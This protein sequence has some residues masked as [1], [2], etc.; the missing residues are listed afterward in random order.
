MIFLALIVILYLAAWG[1]G[2]KI[3]VNLTPS[4]PRGIYLLMPVKNLSRGS[5]IA[6]CNPNKEAVALYVKRGYLPESHRCSSGAAPII[7][8][9]AAVPGDTVKLDDSGVSINDQHIDHSQ[10]EDLDSNGHPIPHLLP[11]IIS[12]AN[13]H[14]FVMSTHSARSLD[15]RYFGPIQKMD[16]I[17]QV[18]PLYTE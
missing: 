18:K 8:P 14:F 5:L 3:A 2:Y 15:S 9:I 7:K 1:S 10:I 11:G 4:M 17:G 16:V 6:A 12:L 13:D